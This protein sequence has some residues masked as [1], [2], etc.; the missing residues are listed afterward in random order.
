[1]PE[2]AATIGEPEPPVVPDSTSSRRARPASETRDR[3]G[4][5][6]AWYRLVQ[7]T[8]ATL[9]TALVGW[10]ATGQSNLPPTGAVL[11]VSNHMSFFDVILLG[12]AANRPLNYVA[13]STL[14]LPG[15]GSFISSVGAF[16]IQRE[17]MGASGMKETLRRLKN[18]GIVALFPEGTRS[19]DGEL[20]PLKNGIAVLVARA[21][22]PV[23]PVGLAGTFELWPRTR[24]L[25]GFHP[26]RAHLGPPI[27]PEELKGMETAD[28]AE[29]IRQKMEDCR[30]EAIRGLRLDLTC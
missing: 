20:G 9:A 23:V 28:I 21:R 7:Y 1:M 2:V 3:S 24:L 29:L 26:V 22:V 19:V 11:L 30:A 10:R 12:V 15:L 27:Y 4:L 16:P 18:G 25:P 6:T 13:R 14:F 5:A 8:C 17:G